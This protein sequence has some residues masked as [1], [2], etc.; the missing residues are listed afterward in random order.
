MP[1]A[2]HAS[3]HPPAW[4]FFGNL[5]DANKITLCGEESFG[6]GSDHVREK[7]GLWAVLFW[8]NLVATKQ[9]SVEEIV[10]EHWTRFGRNYYCRHDYEGIDSDNANGLM[11]HLRD[12]LDALKGKTLS[13]YEIDHCDD[14]CYTD[15]VDNSI[16]EQQGI[17][18]LFNDG[19]RIVYRLSGYRH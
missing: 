3:K 7:D 19:S 10:R 4:K 1:S 12:S 11:Q 18:L 8:L 15:P 13:D 9:Q 14:F 6:T 2:F 16:S 17:R 5:L